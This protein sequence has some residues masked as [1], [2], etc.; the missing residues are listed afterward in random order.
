[1]TVFVYGD[2]HD[3]KGV[4]VHSLYGETHKTA[5][6]ISCE[7]TS[8]ILLNETTGKYYPNIKVQATLSDPSFSFTKVEISNAYNNNELVYTASFNGS[9]DITE[10]ILNDKAYLVKVYYKNSLGAEQSYENYVYVER[11]D[12]P[13][14]NYNMGY[15]LLDDVILGF[16]F[17]ENKSNFE[18]LTVKI[19]YEYSAQYIAEDAIYLLDNPNAI[20]DLRAQLNSMDRAEDGYFELGLKINQLERVEEYIEEYY[21]SLTRQDW[22]AELAKGIY[23]YEYTFGKT[24][25]FFKG[26]NNHYYAVLPDYQ[27]KRI[28]DSSWQYVITADVDLNNGEGASARELVSGYFSIKPALSENDYLFV[29]SDKDYKQLFTLDENNVVSLEVMSRNN[30]GNES[31]RQL[32]YVN[33]IVLAKG[34]D[35]VH[36]LWTQAEPDHSIDEAAWLTNLKAALIA[37]NKP[38][39][40]FPLGELKP[41]TFDLDGVDLSSC[42]AGEYDI[43]FT[44]KMYGKTYTQENPY[45]FNGSTIAYTVVN[46]LPQASIKINTEATDSYGEFEIVIPK[47]VGNGYWSSYTIEIRNASEQLVGTYTQENYW[48]FGKLSVNYSIRVKLTAVDYISYYLDGEWSEWFVCNA[49]K[50]AT[51]TGFTQSY[52]EN[53]VTVSWEFVSGAEKFVYTVNGGAEQET[54]E[55]RV[56]SLKNGD[57]LK[58]KA[59]PTASSNYL[60][61]DYSESFTVTDSRTPLAAPVVTFNESRYLLTWTAVENADHYDVY[62][63]TKNEI[64]RQGITETRCYVESGTVYIVKAIPSDSS[65]YIASQSERIDTTLTLENPKITVDENG[66]VSFS[67]YPSVK[68]KVTYTYV[69]NSGTE[70]TTTNP[71]D[72]A[73]LKTGDVIKVKVSCDGYED[74]E[75][76]SITV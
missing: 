60:A 3:G 2:L 10:N 55:T 65:V 6:V 71:Y 37:G 76:V 7:V 74:S 17:G 25:Q 20:E 63:V 70:Q 5:S 26:A 67:E 38:E 58:V 69:I 53:G 39:S 28:N 16:D 23:L 56:S 73:T 41:I 40:V 14:V 52:D 35:I 15:G 61:S 62:N 9:K 8:Q 21:S 4:A 59:V 27:T 48:E 54:S 43:R 45:D 42:P 75:W 1:M 64:Y 44:Y 18:N 68:G 12:Y 51:P 22:Q 49:A 30:L 32:G 34:Y 11:L 24:E 72:V 19:F 33:Q 47:S 46:K 50:C 57:T 13:S 29:A 66:V 36:V 31:Y